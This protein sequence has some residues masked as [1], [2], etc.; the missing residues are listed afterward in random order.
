MHSE[1]PRTTL[2]YL[3]PM[4]DRA[5]TVFRVPQSHSLHIAP[6]ACNR[7]N[8]LSAFRNEDKEN[9]SCL[10]I[11]EEDVVSGHYENII[12]DAV[13]DLLEVLTPRPRIFLLYF[14]CIDD[15]LGTDEESLLNGLR[16][17]FPDLAF[18]A[19]HIN[20]VAL[21]GKIMPG[22]LLQSRLYSF[23]EKSIERDNGVNHVGGF[24]PIPPQCEIHE[25][26]RQL[27]I[28]PIRSL[29]TSTTYEDY[30]AMAKSRFTLVTSQ[31]AELAAQEMEKNAGV[32][33]CLC[34][35]TFNP[36]DIVT[37]YRRITDILGEPACDF[38]DACEKAYIDIKYTCD[39]LDGIPLI[40]GH[41]IPGRTFPLARLLLDNGFNL[42]LVFASRIFDIDRADHEWLKKNHPEV[43]I[44]RGGT[45]EHLLGG[46][47]SERKTLTLGYE[48]AQVLR[49]D[50]VID[51]MRDEGM[52]G[53]Y[54]LH[55]LLE[56]MREAVAEKINWQERPIP[57]R[58]PGA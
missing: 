7:R 57:G 6:S 54:G 51:F 21:D 39:V 40:L 58:N 20:P 18:V 46:G 22:M 47:E 53:F 42:K 31:M 1:I 12:G 44:E 10:N 16:Q 27:G 36:E 24:V 3:S 2:A 56:M 50:H 5:K 14:K 11:T 41:S 32:P 15:F 33:Y 28:G 43:R 29:F 8:V 48:S 23:L 37:N 13:D 4:R 55:R 34:Y 52:F 19:C 17:R 35:N 25:L 49:T 30:S 45:Y 26:Y 9:I 38:N